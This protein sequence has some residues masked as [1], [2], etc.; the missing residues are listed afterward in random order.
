MYFDN[1]KYLK[2]FAGISMIKSDGIINLMDIVSAK[3]TNSIA[4]NVTSNDLTNCHCRNVR[5]TLLAIKLLLIT[6]IICYYYA[7]QKGKI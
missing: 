4:T 2:F 3:K 1:I 7:K 6:I 5:D